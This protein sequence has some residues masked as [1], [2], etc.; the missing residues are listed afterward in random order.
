MK[1][2]LTIDFFWI[3]ASVGGHRSDPYSGMR[4]TIRW[5][6]HIEAFLQRARDVECGTLSFDP[7]KAQGKAT[8]SFLSSDPVPSDW[9]REG[10]LVELLSGY[11]VLAVG[12]ITEQVVGSV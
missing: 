4:L 10:E 12:R 11:R 6:R 1:K 5:Q 2:I 7:E 9:L 8:F 3:P